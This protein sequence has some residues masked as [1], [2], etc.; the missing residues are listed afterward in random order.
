[1]AKRFN[2]EQERILNEWARTA[3]ELRRA[4]PYTTASETQT[5]GLGF[6]LN[7]EVDPDGRFYIRVRESDGSKDLDTAYTITFSSNDFYLEYGNPPDKEI[8]VNFA[9]STSAGG[10]GSGVTDHGALTG[11]ADD[12]HLQ[13]LLAS[14]AGGRAAFATN[15]TDLTDG[16]QTT[17]HTH[18][19]GLLAGL[20]DDDHPQYA[21]KAASQITFDGVVTAEAFYMA[22]NGDLSAITRNLTLQNPSRRDTISFFSAEADFRVTKMRSILRQNDSGFYPFVNF[23]LRHSLN[24]PSRLSGTELVT[25]GWQCGFYPGHP[26]LT[27]D[28]NPLTVTSFNSSTIPKDSYVWL[29]TTNLGEG[30]GIEE[31][32]AVSLWIER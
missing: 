15:W 26:Y 30:N 31:E 21:R 3:S 28:K 11:L 22:G 5:K 4:F 6:L 2:P 9:G 25:G 24:F 14:D 7:K 16:G 12:D 18:D 13:Y 29:E 23:T 17:L 8:I 32:L 1:M 10:G 19:H 20:G 27:A